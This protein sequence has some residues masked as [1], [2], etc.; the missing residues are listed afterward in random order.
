MSVLTAHSTNG[1]CIL[2]VSVRQHNLFATMSEFYD[3]DQAYDDQMLEEIEVDDS[4]PL[5]DE[6][7]A[8]NDLQIES[9]A[10]FIAAED[11]AFVTFSGHSDSVYC[12]AMH[13]NQPGVVITGEF[14][15]K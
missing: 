1:C 13:P 11:M 14:F 15:L 4:A 5:D 7:D 2:G 6:S 12:V 10:D 3:D 9:A 8:G